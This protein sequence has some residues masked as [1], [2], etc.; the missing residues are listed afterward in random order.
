[1][2]PNPPPVFRENAP[3]TRSIV[4]ARVPASQGIKTNLR[5]GMREED[6]KIVGHAWVEYQQEPIN[7][8]DSWLKAT[9]RLAIKEVGSRQV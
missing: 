1:M 7:D 3:A 6:G 4:T 5:I 9:Q 2:H 8:S